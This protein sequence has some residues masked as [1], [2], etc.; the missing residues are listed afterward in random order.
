[1]P[2]LNPVWTGLRLIPLAILASSNGWVGWLTESGLV[3]WLWAVSWGG[4][5]L[6][7]TYVRAFVKQFSLVDV[8]KLCRVRNPFEWPSPRYRIGY[9]VY[10]TCRFSVWWFEFCLWLWHICLDDYCSSLSIIVVLSII[11]ISMH[12]FD[13]GIFIYCFTL[14]WWTWTCGVCLYSRICC[15]WVFVA[16]PDFDLG[17]FE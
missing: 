6:G 2:P 5:R 9:G 3:F 10:L 17:D 13:H 4:P 12:L 8:Y 16:N 11:V 15:C 1:M 14:T 7:V